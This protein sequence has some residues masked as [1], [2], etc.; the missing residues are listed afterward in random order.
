LNARENQYVFS[1]EL[2]V[3]SESLSVTVLGRELQVAKSL[4]F[5]TLEAHL[6]TELFSDAY[7]TYDTV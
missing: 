7:D 5:T 3:P 1:L 6:K 2:N 4:Y